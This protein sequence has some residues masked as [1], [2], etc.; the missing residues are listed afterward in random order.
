MIPV[1]DEIQS[2]K[3]LTRLKTPDGAPKLPQGVIPHDTTPVMTSLGAAPWTIGPPESPLQAE[4]PPVNGPV[5]K[6]VSSTKSPLR[7][8]LLMAA[9][10]ASMVIL[11]KMAF[12]K[13]LT[14]PVPPFDPQ[15]ARVPDPI[16]MTFG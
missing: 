13:M 5:Q 14:A 10:Q 8:K 2:L 4:S 12:C 11:G 6:L 15:P 16:G 7:F 3:A 1:L 9:R